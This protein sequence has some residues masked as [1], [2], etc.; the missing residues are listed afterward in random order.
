MQPQL[1]QRLVMGCQWAHGRLRNYLA[2]NYSRAG[3]P[4]V[5]PEK[6]DRTDFL[7]EL[8]SR[9]GYRTY[10][11]IGCW[12]DDCF[13][14]IAA[15]HKV[16]VDPRSGGTLRLTSDDFFA[17]NAERFDLIFIDGLHLYE[18]VRK[19]ILH[20]LEV[21]ED[22]GTIV[23]HDCVPTRCIEQYD[24]QVTRIWT[25][26]VWK[27]MV[28]AR[29]WEG[30]DAVTCLID[31]G[32]GV[33]RKRANGDPLH[34]PNGNFKSLRFDFLAADYRRLLRAVGFDTALAFATNGSRDETWRP[35]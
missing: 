18:Q 23:L 26:D 8:I 22:G 30:V 15:P 24:T 29:T 19:D 33:L 35:Q 13:S 6:P 34:L 11:E 10:L 14:K 16:G 27:A 1:V 32:L 5:F 28:E 17:R 2:G 4:V 9:N 20:S 7:N 21:L 25:G 31:F 12:N 3:I